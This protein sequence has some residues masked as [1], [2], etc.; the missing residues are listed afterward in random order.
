MA[1]QIAA[2]AMTVNDLEGHSRIA[3]CSNTIFYKVVEQLTR[4]KL[5][6]PSRGPSAVAMRLGSEV[7]VRTHTEAH[8]ADR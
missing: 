6:R 1:N 7:V 3:S 2:I 5:I 8:T 4:F